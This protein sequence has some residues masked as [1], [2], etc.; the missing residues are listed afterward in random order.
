MIIIKRVRRWIVKLIC[1]PRI[2][3]KEVALTD[4]TMDQLDEIKRYFSRPKFFILGYARS[5]T[6]LLARLMRLHPDVHCNWQ[7]HFF[8]EANSLFRQ[9]TT[10]G[11]SAWLNRPNNRWAYDKGLHTP[12]IRMICDFILEREAD[13]F[14]KRIVGD[15]TPNQDNGAI[16][17]R[18]HLVYPYATLIYIVRDG[19]DVAISKRIQAFIDDPKNLGRRDLQIMEAMRKNNKLFLNGERTIFTPKWLEQLS[20]TWAESTRSNDKVGREFFGDRYL[21]LRYEDLLADPYYQIAR[22]WRGLGVD[23]DE[24]MLKLKVTAEMQRNPA[25]D[26]HAHSDPKLVMNLKRGLAG[27]WREMMTYQDRAMF[28][29]MAGEVLLSWGYPET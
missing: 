18:L 13:E 29:K 7:A 28:W 1:T 17:R 19:R 24:G 22:L 27:E 9:M 4:L 2:S 15:K 6:T 23:L 3:K 10:P 14:G 12:L 8:T 25:A 21:C 26:W 11:M 5:G 16:I 20:R